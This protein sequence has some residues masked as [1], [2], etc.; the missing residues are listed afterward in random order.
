MEAMQATSKSYLWEHHGILQI[1]ESRKPCEIAY[2]LTTR[3]GI[4]HS[5]VWNM[6]QQF[7]GHGHLKDRNVPKLQ[8]NRHGHFT[9]RLKCS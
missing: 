6:D 1:P 2:H 9:E 7:N 5:N 4:Y 3:F 8:T